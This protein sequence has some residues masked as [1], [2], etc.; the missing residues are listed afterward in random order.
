[1]NYHCKY[2]WTDSKTEKEKPSSLIHYI[3]LKFFLL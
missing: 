3:Q 1:M 2:V